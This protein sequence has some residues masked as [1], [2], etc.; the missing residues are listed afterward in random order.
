MKSHQIIQTNLDF[1]RLLNLA[2]NVIDEYSPTYAENA[3][4]MVFENALIR[5]NIAVGRQPVPVTAGDKRAN[6]IVTL[7]PQPSALML[8]GHIDTVALWH[9]EGHHARISNGKLYGLGAADMKSACTAMTEAIIA[10]ANS[11]VELKQGV[12]L[13][14][15]VGEEEYGDGSK[16][17]VKEYFAPEVVIGEPTQLQLCPSHFGYLECRLHSKGKRAHAALPEVGANAIEAMLS[18]LSEIFTLRK[19]LPFHRELAINPREIH[20]GEPDFVVAEN[21]EA[22]LDFHLPPEADAASVIAI[23]ESAKTKVQQHHPAVDFQ[24]DMLFWSAGYHLEKTAIWKKFN[25]AF[26]ASHLPLNTSAFRSHSDARMFLDAGMNPYICGPGCLT[27]A[28]RRGE[29]VQ[30]DEL[31]QAAQLYA[32]IISEVCV[33]Q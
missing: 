8:V 4:A 23:I 19:T 24:H 16:A 33:S 30:I 5:E 3:A 20:G 18:W 28:H 9:D 26:D 1:Q 14:L 10:V 17:L 27:S 21:C 25:T 7:G 29:F 6:L 12:T 13:A 11:K 15:V 32:A 31:N 22:L 2:V